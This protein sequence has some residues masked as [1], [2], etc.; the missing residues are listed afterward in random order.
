MAQSA[1]RLRPFRLPPAVNQT[2]HSQQAYV[3]PV[4][5]DPACLGLQLQCAGNAGLRSSIAVTQSCWSRSSCIGIG[6]AGIAHFSLNGTESV[7]RQMSKMAPRPSSQIFHKEIENRCSV[8]RYQL[9]D[10]QAPYNRQTQWPAHFGSV[11][12]TQC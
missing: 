9:T 7:E 3:V 2:P 11:A 4:E 6:F 5:A 10:D 12:E 1:R 8:E